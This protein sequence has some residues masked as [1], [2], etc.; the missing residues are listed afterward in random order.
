[1]FLLFTLQWLLFPKALLG[2]T[3]IPPI[4]QIS[5]AASNPHILTEVL[6]YTDPE[7]NGTV[8]KAFVAT[9]IIYTNQR[10]AILV[11]PDWNGRDEYENNRTVQLAELGYVGFAI[12]IYGNGTVGRNPKENT[13][14][15]TP[16]LQ[17]RTKFIHRI[18]VALAKV[19]TLD[20]VDVTK[21][22]NS[23]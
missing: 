21:V 12:D 3:T 14:L 13:A 20:N 16:F 2:E 22:I 8:F 9:N 17:N 15:M 19:K 23:I 18:Q 11:V 7:A 1:M 5:Y 4:P 10:P 6:E